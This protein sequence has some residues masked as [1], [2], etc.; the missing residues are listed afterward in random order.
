MTFRPNPSD[1]RG[2]SPPDG[3]SRS[4]ATQF[5]ADEQGML[6]RPSREFSIEVGLVDQVSPLHRIVVS[7]YGDAGAGSVHGAGKNIAV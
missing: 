1:S 4:L 7:R 3:N 2:K 6:D 5:S